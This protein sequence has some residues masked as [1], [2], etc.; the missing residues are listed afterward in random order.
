[1]NHS[2]AYSP[3][4]YG[5]LENVSLWLTSPIFLPFVQTC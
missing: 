4:F 1:L 5:Y 3:Y 2:H